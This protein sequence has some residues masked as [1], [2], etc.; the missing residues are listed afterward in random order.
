M[1][2][3]SMFDDSIEL[4]AEDG[5]YL[6]GAGESAP[7]LVNNLNGLENFINYLDSLQKDFRSWVITDQYR[8]M[9]F[10]WSAGRLQFSDTPYYF[11]WRFKGDGPG[12]NSLQERNRIV[13]ELEAEYAKAVG[14][15]PGLTWQGWVVGR[16]LTALR[17]YE[18][19]FPK[20]FS[21]TIDE[22]LALPSDEARRAELYRYDPGSLYDNL[23]IP[24]L[25]AMNEFSVEYLKEL[26][27]GV[28]NRPDLLRAINPA[29][30]DATVSFMNYAAFF[31]YCKASFPDAWA[32]FLS[33]IG[34]WA[35][36]PMVQTPTV[37]YEKSNGAVEEVFTGR[38]NQAPQIAD[39]PNLRLKPG[40]TFHVSLDR[41]V[42]DEESPF[43]SLVWTVDHP[44]VTIDRNSHTASI[45][46]PPDYS[47]NSEAVATFRVAD[48]Q[49]LTDTRQMTLSIRLSDRR[50]RHRWW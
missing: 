44:L 45:S 42:N 16:L 2:T 37:L 22:I 4:P 38:P 35:P 12:F 39:W 10:R 24:L 26:S 8:D 50:S 17:E 47:G 34:E 21:G 29:V 19:G 49:G 1:D 36:V 3:L 25:E 18:A 30:W 33:G 31:R 27:Y 5:K 41:F 20:L 28:S 46:I 9:V 6:L 40:Q 32:R 11:F 48:P 7:N 14:A 23:L 43:S 13:Q 15:N